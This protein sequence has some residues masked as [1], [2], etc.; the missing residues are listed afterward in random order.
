MSI[1]DNLPIQ[2]DPTTMEPESNRT[3]NYRDSLPGAPKP[4]YAR[5]SFDESMFRELCPSTSD[6]TMMNPTTTKQSP[7]E[8]QQQASSPPPALPQKSSLRASRVLDAL[9]LKLDP[10]ANEPTT[11]ARTTAPHEVYLSSEEDASSSADDFSDYDF[12]SASDHDEADATTAKTT[13]A[14]TGSSSSS[15]NNSRKRSYEDI[16][17]AVAVVFSGKPT[18]VQITT[19]TAKRSAT[20]S[21]TA[22]RSSTPNLLSRRLSIA[23]SHPPRS[24]SLALHSNGSQPAFLDTDPYADSP[25][26]EVVEAGT[27]NH[28]ANPR[29]STS[30]LKKTLGTLVKKRSRPLLKTNF[31]NSSLTRLDRTC[32]S[33]PSI[34]STSQKEEETETLKTPTTPLTPLSPAS[35]TSTM[36]VTYREI[37]KNAKRNAANVPQ[38]PGIT[39]PASSIPPEKRSRLLAGLSMSRR[40]SIRAG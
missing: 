30:V 37:I 17:K 15:S 2:P 19:T 38:S 4:M 11:L 24:T 27:S 3:I 20:P 16:A 40:R 23:T 8:A 26:L 35:R 18:I 36:P 25:S 14:A 5:E 22:S 10:V 7:T 1:V 34:Q 39:S 31:S 6:D 13:A 32:S 29:S 28:H 9:T 33:S 21:T 12:D